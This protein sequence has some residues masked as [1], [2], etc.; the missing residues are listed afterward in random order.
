MTP[1][2]VAILGSALLLI[3]L[4]AALTVAAVIN[5]GFNVLTLVSLLVLALL[6]FGILGALRT[7]PPD[8]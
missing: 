1:T 5:G 4:L 3:A 7:P 2:R 6:G 8:E